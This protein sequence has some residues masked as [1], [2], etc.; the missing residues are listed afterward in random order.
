MMPDPWKD[1]ECNLPQRLAYLRAQGG[2][3]I[4]SVEVSDDGLELLVTFFGDRP[5]LRKEMVVISGGVRVREIAVIDLRLD[6]DDGNDLPD[7][8]RVFVDRRGDHS[9]YTLR[10]V[11]LDRDG[12]PTERPLPELDRRYRQ[13]EFRF[14]AGGPTE[15]DCVRAGASVAAAAGDVPAINYLAKDFA[16]FRQLILDRLALTLPTWTER[17][18]PD[19]GMALVEVLAYV[20]DYLSYYQDA[21]GTEA[22]LSTARQRISVK[23]HVKLLDYTMHEGANA[24]AWMALTTSEDLV[25][26]GLAADA[27]DFVARGSDNEDLQGRDETIFQ[28]VLPD[29]VQV[30]KAHNAISVYTWGDTEC[31]LPK[32]AT[33]ATLKDAWRDAD[34]IVGR[35]ERRERMLRLRVGDWLLFKEAKGAVSGSPSDASS[36]RRQVVRLTKVEPIV[37]RLY[38]QPVVEIEWEAEDALRFPLTLSSMGAAPDCASIADV[39]VAVGNIVLADQG[40]WISQQADGGEEVLGTVPLRSVSRGCRDV[41]DPGEIEVRGGR[42]R[43]VLQQ[44]PLVFRQGFEA[45]MAAASALAQDPRQ[46]TPQI[47]VRSIA[48]L[49]DGSGP[50]V[51]PGELTDVS[52]LAER[53]LHGTDDATAVLREQAP[54]YVLAEL[55]QHGSAQSLT[56]TLLRALEALTQ[57]YA[58]EWTSVPDLLSSTSRDA[59]VTVEMR[60]DGA[61]QL[62]FGDG[63]MGRAPEAGALFL[64]DYR[65]STSSAEAFSAGVID[66]MVLRSASPEGIVLAAENP[67]AAAA[68]IAPEEMAKVKLLAPGAYRN[69]RKRAITAA[70]Y[71]AIAETH[72]GVERAASALEWTGTRYEVKVV[73]DPIGT[74]AIVEELLDSV[75]RMLQRYRR[76]GHDLVVTQAEYVPLDLVMDVEIAPDYLNAHVKAALLGAFSSGLDET[77]QPAL[78]HPDRLTFGT[79][80]YASQL[81]AAAQAADGV[82]SAT[83]MRLRRLYAQPPVEMHSGVLAIGPLE[84]A[85]LDADPAHPENGRLRINVRGGR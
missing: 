52:L 64:A 71:A 32:G 37:D 21:V 54:S 56:P 55:K 48:G 17:H 80:V 23:R 27:I 39:G 11:E 15:I 9:T 58:T 41:R 70:D 36:K 6:D 51:S 61:A 7:A 2:N 3:G 10:L 42:F 82:V 72:R 31:V 22:Y 79:A 60:D 73:I 30:Y 4:D 75:D 50:I 65:V 1:A 19:L 13:A 74:D 62:R 49:P 38:E 40:Q 66:R 57:R 16:T 12:R 78:F 76:I 8:V 26:P 69:T 25:A 44:S 67:L 29:Q 34:E 46:A 77:G 14:H 18:V 59:H 68:V 53:L 28:P 5:E 43:P 84:V 24:R 85:R 63:V 45:G 20:A 35:P 47:R 83:V 81:L 33:R